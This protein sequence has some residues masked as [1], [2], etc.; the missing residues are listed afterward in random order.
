[1]LKTATIQCGTSVGGKTLSNLVVKFY[2]PA[3]LCFCEP[4]VQQPATSSKQDHSVIAITGIAATVQHS[5]RNLTQK[6]IRRKTYSLSLIQSGITYCMANPP[7]YSVVTRVYS[8]DKCS[9]VH[10]ISTERTIHSNRPHT[11]VLDNPTKEDH[12]VDVAVPNSH[13]TYSTITR[14]SRSMQT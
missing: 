3:D 2:F 13:N 4:T 11:A 1:V 8:R 6:T 5:R 12:S 14:N 7:P 9:Q 10:N